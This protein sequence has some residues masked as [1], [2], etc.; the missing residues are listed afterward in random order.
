MFSNLLDGK[1]EHLY[2]INCGIEDFILTTKQGKQFHVYYQSFNSSAKPIECH[3]PFTS[4]KPPSMI[5]IM[6]TLYSNMS[7]AI[8][9]EAFVEVLEPR[10]QAEETDIEQLA[11]LQ[12]TDKY[13]QSLQEILIDNIY[14]GDVSLFNPYLQ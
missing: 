11:Q 2:C 10:E 14:P 13:Y 12:Q 1:L 3:G 9:K 4:T 5:E 8:D 6:V 7:E